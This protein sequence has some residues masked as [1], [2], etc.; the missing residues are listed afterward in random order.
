M[1]SP[2]SF[3]AERRLQT[4]TCTS[5]WM[6]LRLTQYEPQ[7]CLCRYHLDASDGSAL[8]L[9]EGR[10]KRS[11]SSLLA[12][13]AYRDLGCCSSTV[14]R[15]VQSVPRRGSRTALT[16]LHLACVSDGALP[17]SR[18]DIGERN[19]DESHQKSE[20]RFRHRASPL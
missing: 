3:S 17:K 16:A 11:Q 6:E 5:C 15:I 1:D 20:A 18:P 14:M 19:A 9:F 4:Q 8:H 10:R 13:R 7:L 2:K 12:S